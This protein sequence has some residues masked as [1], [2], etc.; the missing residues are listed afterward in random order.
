MKMSI[1]ITK[2]ESGILK[3][4]VLNADVSQELKERLEDMY[5]FEGESQLTLIDKCEI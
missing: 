5:E 1:E 2:A 4:L 3:D